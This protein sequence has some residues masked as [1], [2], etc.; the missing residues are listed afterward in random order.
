MEEVLGALTPNKGLKVAGGDRF[1][2]IGALF[3]GGHELTFYIR[4]PCGLA[5]RSLNA[6]R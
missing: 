1:N 4:A 5:A 2:G 6:I 3:P